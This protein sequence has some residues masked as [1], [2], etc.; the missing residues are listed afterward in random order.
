MTK[1]IVG[2][3]S[4]P[5]IVTA[6]VIDNDAD[7]DRRP[8]AISQCPADIFNPGFC[9]KGDVGQGA[10]CISKT[11]YS[12]GNAL[13]AT[14][15]LSRSEEVQ[16]V[17][18]RNF[19]L[20]GVNYN[21]PGHMTKC[22]VGPAP[23]PAHPAT[24]TP[25]PSTVATTP[26]PTTPNPP[27][28]NQCPADIFNPGFCSR[29]D[30]GDG[31]ACISNTIYSGGNALLATKVLSK[32]EEVQCVPA[33]LHGTKGIN[34][35]CPSDMIKCVV[36]TTSVS[37]NTNP[38]YNCPAEI[39]SGF[40]S[41]HDLGAGGDACIHSHAWTNSNGNWKL[42]ITAPS[43]IQC[44]PKRN[45]PHGNRANYKCPPGMIKCFYK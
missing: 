38:P 23:I 18:E 2:P 21:C 43:Q 40:C 24:T 12:G 8:P 13:L 1:C 29:A 39:F 14:K 19:G 9:E 35:N 17:P 16:C 44:V 26:T 28:L 41:R 3:G 31:A 25:L 20:N 36:G 33:R 45:W 4:I 30:V 34:Y 42:H 5:A 32:S 37:P 6:I 11:I 15:V 22:V 27:A 10:A 7:S